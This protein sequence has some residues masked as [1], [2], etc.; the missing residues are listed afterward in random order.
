MSCSKL[1]WDAQAFSRKQVPTVQDALVCCDKQTLLYVVERAFASRMPKWENATPQQRH[2]ARKRMARALDAMRQ[3]QIKRKEGKS[4]CV[5]PEEEFVVYVTGGRC[6]IERALRGRIADVSSRYCREDS[7][8]GGQDRLSFDRCPWAVALAY[9]IWLEGPWN[10]QERY[11]I[12]ASV[13]WQLT[14]QGFGNADE[15][16]EAPAEGGLQAERFCQGYCEETLPFAL[17]L[18]RQPGFAV[19]NP[20]ECSCGQSDVASVGEEHAN[21]AQLMGL[22]VPEALEETYADRLISRVAQLNEI[23]EQD[24]QARVLRFSERLRAA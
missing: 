17:G 15:E 2:V 18:Q 20:Y 8:R 4:Y 16:A 3:C 24:F 9:R 11:M 13:F 23:G 1:L 5:F 12:L 21:R 6:A 7:L 14:H 10:C 22:G 19:A